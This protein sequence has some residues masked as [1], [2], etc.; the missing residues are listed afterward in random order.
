MT[1]NKLTPIEMQKI[2]VELTI[3]VLAGVEKR[4]FGKK[5]VSRITA[6]L[7]NLNSNRNDIAML[8][9]ALAY[10]TD[11]WVFGSTD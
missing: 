4:F 3:D 2:F 5:E 11:G 8:N 1:I 9:S 7:T 6:V 10:C